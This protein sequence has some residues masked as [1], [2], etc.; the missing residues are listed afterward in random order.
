LKFTKQQE[1]AQLLS[2]YVAASALLASVCA[3]FLDKSIL[4]P[5]LLGYGSFVTA[6]IG[7]FLASFAIFYKEWFLGLPR[8]VRVF[9]GFA[10]VFLKFFGP[11]W[12]IWMV[13]RAGVWLGLVGMV[14]AMVS[15]FFSA[16]FMGRVRKKKNVE[17]SEDFNL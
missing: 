12:M 10:A 2:N 17:E 15:L 8:I 11:G 4:F 7:L 1:L 3:V 16:I 9:Y 13:V 5:L 6:F 14:L